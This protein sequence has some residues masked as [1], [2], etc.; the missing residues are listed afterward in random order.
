MLADAYGPKRRSKVGSWTNDE[1]VLVSRT[2]ELTRFGHVML[3]IRL[4][5]FGCQMAAAEPEGR[6]RG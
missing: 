6:R 5:R 2:R 1:R 4:D 3:D